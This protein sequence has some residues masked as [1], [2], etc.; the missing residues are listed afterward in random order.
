MHKPSDRRNYF[1]RDVV[2]SQI[3]S[4]N[5]I[6]CEFR[7]IILNSRSGMTVCPR[8][9]DETE[10][11]GLKCYPAA[12]SSISLCADSILREQPGHSH[13]S[14]LSLALPAYCIGCRS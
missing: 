3:R 13:P 14:L 6:P 4:I 10:L 9:L 8:Q 1:P 12:Q 5:A 11:P 7:L 2:A